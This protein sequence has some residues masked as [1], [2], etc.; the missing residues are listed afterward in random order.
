VSS[1]AVT[2]M[3]PDDAELLR[4][5]RL[6]LLKAFPENFSADPDY[7]STLTPDQ[8]RERLAAP[9]RH[10]FL[11]R[12][13]GAVAGLC[14]F[15]RASHTKKEAHRGDIG[16]MYVRAAFHGTGVA[17]ALMKAVLDAADDTVELI[18]LTVNAENKR[19]IAF[20]E[21]YGFRECGRMPRAI[22]VD[23]HYY[24]EIEMMRVV[25]ASD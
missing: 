17:D 6:E 9:S 7:E 21:R 8:W 10:W 25:S 12:V 4:E 22:N 3:T 1:A 24:D 23:G 13:D 16:S 5:L 2:R 15:S 19:A 14:I 11:C 20:Y 18:S